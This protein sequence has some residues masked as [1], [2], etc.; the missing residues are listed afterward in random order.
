MDVSVYIHLRGSIP[1][2]MPFPCDTSQKKTFSDFLH[3]VYKKVKTQQANLILLRSGMIFPP[4][5]FSLP[6]GAW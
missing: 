5:C 1:Q 4:Q 6:D 3:K 2:Q